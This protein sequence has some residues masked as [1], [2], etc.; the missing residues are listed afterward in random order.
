MYSVA[1]KRPLAALAVVGGLLVTVAP[2]SAK[3]ESPKDTLSG[4]HTARI[5][6]RSVGIHVVSDGTS[7]TVIYASVE[8]RHQLPS[9]ASGAPTAFDAKS[10]KEGLYFSAGSPAGTQ[11]R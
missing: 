6:P 9:D 7:N 11:N 1:L 2:A 3:V 4:V 8:D 10:S 5:E